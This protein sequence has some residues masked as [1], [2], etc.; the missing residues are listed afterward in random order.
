MY[1]YID[2][3]NTHTVYNVH[4]HA[5]ALVLMHIYSV[6]IYAH[7]YTEKIIPTYVYS[8]VAIGIKVYSPVRCKDYINIYNLYNNI[9]II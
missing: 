4:A 6:Y 7:M 1:M 2:I 3:Y 5:C 8:Q 9:I